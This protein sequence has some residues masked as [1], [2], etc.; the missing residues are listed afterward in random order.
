M[1]FTEQ[2]RA[3]QQKQRSLLCVGLDTDPTKLPSHLRL[4]PD[5]V[6]DFNRRV[7]DATADAACAFKINLAFTEALGEEGPRVLRRT[8]MH[9]PAGVIT[10][11]DGK[12]GDIGN[13]SAM[14]AKALFEDLNFT[15]CTVNPYMGSDAVAPFL[16]RPDRGAFI[17][18]VTSNPGAKDF[19]YLSV[20]G[21]PLYMHVIA[22]AKKWGENCGL[23]VGATRP[24][25][26]KKVR[27]L[28]PSMPILIPGVGT[29]GGDMKSA[30]RYGCAKT[31]DLALINV[32]RSII[33]ASDASD[34]HV[35]VRK[36]A[37]ELR[38]GMENYRQLYFTS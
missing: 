2:L 22:K 26:L 36:K 3:A 30:I 13:S 7:I 12:R 28:V 18:A 24:A 21:K 32:S 29:Q 35:A 8:L 4:A 5:G 33:Y 27:A 20:K 25:E 10:I 17:L 23:V 11:A 9:I 31:G 14:Y 19:Q 15:S 16:S 1:T 6:L 38:D 37:I 34:F